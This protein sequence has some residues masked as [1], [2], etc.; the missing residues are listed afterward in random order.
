[1]VVALRGSKAF[2]LVIGELPG[3]CAHQL[4]VAGREYDGSAVS[5]AKLTGNGSIIPDKSHGKTCVAAE[6]DY[7]A[8]SSAI[9]G[10]EAIRVI[11]FAGRT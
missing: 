11:A 8:V 9:S 5:Y 7:N 6:G 1:M 3:V 2:P 4:Q 10:S